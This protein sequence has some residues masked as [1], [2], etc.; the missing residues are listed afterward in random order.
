MSKSSIYRTVLNQRKGQKLQ[1]EQSLFT[2]EESLKKAKKL[3]RYHEQAKTVIKEV[4]LKTQQQLQFHISD[5]ATMALT[6]VLDNP[7]QL[8]AEFIERRDKTECDL[9]FTKGE[10]K[11]DPLTEAGGGAVDIATFALRIG[12]WSMQRPHSRNTIVLDEP[13]KNLSPEYKERG[14]EMIKM[15]SEKLNIQFIIVNHE[16]ALTA[17]ADKVFK[18]YKKNKISKIE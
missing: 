6:A 15:V 1:I 9:F 2:A 5:I 8:I 7:Y 16:V 10:E 11:L 13:M 18:I 17:N 12:S 3:L 4:G 14:S